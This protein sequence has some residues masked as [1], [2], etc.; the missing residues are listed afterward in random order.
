MRGTSIVMIKY[1]KSVVGVLSPDRQTGKTFKKILFC[2]AAL[3]SSA[4]LET[5]G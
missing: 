4:S 2:S 3:T 5:P 1:Q